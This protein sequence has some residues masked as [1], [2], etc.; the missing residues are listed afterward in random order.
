[1][2][3]LYNRW[4]SSLSGTMEGVT[5]VKAEMVHGP[6]LFRDTVS[7]HKSTTT[8]ALHNNSPLTGVQA[9]LSSIC[10]GSHCSNRGNTYLA[11]D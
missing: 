9:Q 2:T 4:N 3:L 10:M 8:K 7:M 1:M 6:L 5:Q 11:H